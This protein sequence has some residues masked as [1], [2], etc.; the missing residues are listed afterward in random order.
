[1]QVRRLTA[2]AILPVVIAGGVAACS[3]DKSS[4]GNSSDSSKVVLSS[5]IGEPKHIVPTNAG[6]T[7]GG[8][9]VYMT[10]AGLLDYDKDGKPYG[11]IADSISTSDNK[12][13]TVKLKDGFTFHNGEK[14]TS[15]NYIN[16]WN[17]GAYGPNGQDVNYFFEKIAGYAD[18][19]P[20]TPRRRRRP[21]RVRPE[22]GRRPDLH[23]DARPSRTSTSRPMLGYTAFYPLPKAAFSAPGVLPRTLRAGADRQG[24]FK[25]K[26]T[27]QHDAKI[28]VERYDA[29]PGEKPKVKVAGIEFRIYQQLTA[30]V[31]GRAGRTTSTSTVRTIPTENLS[32]APSRPR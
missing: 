23:G 18:L 25:M 32:T 24:P 2:L 15:E 14:V 12:V 26:G 19:N 30:R 29:Y 5:Y 16:A 22:E 9:V 31:R 21:R 17:Y 3:G 13:W 28:E 11:M 20:R 7:E 10:F 8:Q 6:E 27:W 4:S 1:M